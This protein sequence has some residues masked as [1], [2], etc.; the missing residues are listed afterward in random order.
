MTDFPIVEYQTEYYQR[1]EGHGRE[2]GGPIDAWRSKISI[3]LRQVT[4]ARPTKPLGANH[5]A[6]EFTTNVTF[7]GGD[8]EHEIGVRYEDFMLDW[9]LA[10]KHSRA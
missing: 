6:D 9:N 3:D 1:F 2:R 10:Q 4:S 8:Q 5:Y 7:V